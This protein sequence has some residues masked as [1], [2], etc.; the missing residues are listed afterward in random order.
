M[1]VS[2][3]L[4]DEMAKEYVRPVR[5]ISTRTSKV[6]RSLGVMGTLHLVGERKAEVEGTSDAYMKIVS[7]QTCYNCV[8]ESLTDSLICSMFIT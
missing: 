2:Q 4:R 1:D 6:K 7:R 3:C 5:G 8:S